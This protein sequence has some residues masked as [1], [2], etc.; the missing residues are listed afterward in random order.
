[1]SDPRD[2]NVGKEAYPAPGG[3]GSGPSASQLPATKPGPGGPTATQP[4]VDPKDPRYDPR[5]DPKSPQFD[6]RM[7]ERPP[8]AT[9][10]P[11]KPRKIGGQD[12]RGSKTSVDGYVDT[13]QH[14]GQGYVN[15][16]VP[17]PALTAE[18]VLEQKADETIQPP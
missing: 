11:A 18:G 1:M 2:T 5:R 3:I 15:V 14:G 10:L 13:T 6:P 17:G 9:Q 12:A 7:A 16:N 4:I 8:Q